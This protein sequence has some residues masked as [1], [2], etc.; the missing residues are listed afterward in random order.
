MDGH[1]HGRNSKIQAGLY[2]LASYN[3]VNHTS[4]DSSLKAKTEEAA[5]VSTAFLATF[6]ATYCNLCYLIFSSM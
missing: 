5:T 3:G 1:I 2:V 6:T 4:K